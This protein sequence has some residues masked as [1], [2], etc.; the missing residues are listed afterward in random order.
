MKLKKQGAE[1]NSS[2]QYL[3]VKV[4]LRGGAEKD[5]FALQSEYN[6]K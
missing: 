2:A 6:Q 4:P 1:V 3:V 5:V